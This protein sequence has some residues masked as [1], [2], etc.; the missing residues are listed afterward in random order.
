MS[1]NKYQKELQSTRVQQNHR[2]KTE[3]NRI[4]SRY[5]NNGQG[6]DP[7]TR[8]GRVPVYGDFSRVPD[9][10]E[11]LQ[12]VQVGIDMWERLPAKVRARFRNDPTKMMEFI[13]DVGN[14]REAAELGLLGAEAVKRLDEVQDTH[15]ADPPAP[16][17]KSKKTTIEEL[18]VQ[19]EAISKQINELE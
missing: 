2:E 5:M 7:L 12:T 17:K 11:A 19:M 8:V 15:P 6:G 9:L 4:V 1:F 18:R 14:Q 16:K 3:I 13:E 10:A